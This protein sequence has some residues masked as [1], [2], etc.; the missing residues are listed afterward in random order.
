[1]EHQSCRRFLRVSLAVA[2][3]IL[4]SGCGPPF[5]PFAPPARLRRVGWLESGTA[6]SNARNLEAFRDGLRD[7]GYIEGQHIAIDFR[8]ADGREERLPDLAGELVRDNVEVIL[9]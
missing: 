3:L 7:L 6:T 1:M 4:L 5:T 9:T 2:S 8:Y